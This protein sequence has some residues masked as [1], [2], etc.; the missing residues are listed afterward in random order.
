MGQNPLK[1]VLGKIKRRFIQTELEEI[2]S[3]IDELWLHE[4]K[5]DSR[6]AWVTSVLSLDAENDMIFTLKNLIEEQKRLTNEVLYNHFQSL[7]PIERPSFRPLVSIVMPVYFEIKSGLNDQEKYLTKS[8]NSIVNQTYDNV[9]GII[10]N[11]GCAEAE[12][13]LLEKIVNEIGDERIRYYRKE[14]GGTSTALNFGIDMMNGEYF[15]W[16]SHDDLY[17]PDHVERHVEHLRHTPIAEKI[18]TTS[19]VDIIDENSNIQIYSTVEEGIHG[20]DYK[21][22]L[23]GR[24]RSYNVTTIGGCSVMIPRNVF[25]IAGRFDVGD[26]ATHEYELWRRIEEEYRFFTIPFC[27][28]AY[29]VHGNSE[30]TRIDGL[31]DIVLR[32]KMKTIDNVPTKEKIALYGNEVNYLRFLKLLYYSSWDYHMTAVA[33]LNERLRLLGHDK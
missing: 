27:T 23:L 1:K 22:S 5:Q 26:R 9:E 18:I 17:Y 6:L 4:K 13:Q 24:E 16:L 31:N 29:R 32:E 30:H 15:A 10:V 28:H 11:D 20:K 19:L 7:K 3:R 12:T 14:N 25:D 8:I 2:N 33:Q 21:K